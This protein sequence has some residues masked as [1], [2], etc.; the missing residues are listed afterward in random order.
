MELEWKNG[1]LLCESII[2]GRINK[3][4]TLLYPMTGTG[5]FRFGLHYFIISYF[6]VT[7][8]LDV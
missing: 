6:S 3:Y 4:L 2:R 1:L 5:H 8:L 7:T